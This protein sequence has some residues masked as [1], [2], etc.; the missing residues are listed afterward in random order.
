MSQE[1]IKVSNRNSDRIARSFSDTKS[2]GEFENIV[3]DEIVKIKKLKYNGEI[4]NYLLFTNRKYS[5]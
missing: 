3:N 1:N 5:G 2:E 4:D